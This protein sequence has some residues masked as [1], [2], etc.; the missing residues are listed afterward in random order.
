M[1]KVKFFSLS[2]LQNLMKSS[3]NYISV[4]GWRQIDACNGARIMG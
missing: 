2:V 4:H 3:I 1:N